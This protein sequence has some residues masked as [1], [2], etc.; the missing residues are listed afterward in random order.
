MNL[1]PAGYRPEPAGVITPLA[2]NQSTTLIHSSDVI[3]QQ[4]V[5][6]QGGLANWKACCG[7]VS[8][9]KKFRLWI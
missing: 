5:L 8:V 2:T 1:E 6:L 3:G 4:I 7:S 9:Y